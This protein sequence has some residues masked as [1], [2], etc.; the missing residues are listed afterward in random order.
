[1]NTDPLEGLLRETLREEASAAAGRLD[2]LE[3]R[4]VEDLG[5]RAPRLG[6]LNGLKQLVAPTRAGRFGQIVVVAAT[7]AAFLAVGALVGK[8]LPLFGGLKVESRET[9]LRSTAKNE[10]LFVLPALNAENVSVVGSFN[11]WEPT[12]LSDEDG[13]G[14]WTARVSV[15]P[16]RYEYA[17]VID[18]RWWGQDPLAD[19]YVRSFGEYSSV[20][21]VGG[22]GDGV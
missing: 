14:I 4:V 10:L 3:Q 17:F 22:G 6:W 20:R 1:M 18:G 15:P 2:G 12:P 16:G 5:D 7:A 11:D 8:D 13:D 9:M 19:E 21:Y